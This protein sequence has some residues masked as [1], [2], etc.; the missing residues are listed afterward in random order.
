MLKNLMIMKM[1]YILLF[2]VKNFILL[3][4]FRDNHLEE[5]N[6][7]FMDIQLIFLAFSLKS[8]K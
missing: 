8:L 5:L 2:Q 3:G 7:C 1:L 6:G 4:L